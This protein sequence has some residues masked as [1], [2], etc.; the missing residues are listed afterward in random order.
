MAGSGREGRDGSPPDLRAGDADVPC[1]I[2][3]DRRTFDDLFAEF[4]ITESERRDLVHFLAAYRYRRTIET[5][6]PQPS[7]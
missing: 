1:P 6:L 2:C 5:L 4:R 3:A 7:T